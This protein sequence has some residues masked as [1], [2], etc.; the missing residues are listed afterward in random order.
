MRHA[1]KV[2][3]T[4]GDHIL[5][6]INGTRESIAEY[7]APDKPFNIGVTGD[8]IQYVTSIEFLKGE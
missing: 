4:N 8:N 6:E 2:N 1:I 3:L 5:T 7:Y